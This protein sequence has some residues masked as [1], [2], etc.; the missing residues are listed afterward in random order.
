MQK[1]LFL[2]M[3][4]LSTMG[5]VAIHP[6]PAMA[7]EAPA[8]NIT[9]KGQVVDDMGEPLTGATIKVKGTATG[10]ITD[11]DGNFELSVDPNATLEVSY[12]GFQNQDVQVNGRTSLPTIKMASDSEIL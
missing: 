8:P 2:L 1:Q 10:T 12:V 11:L 6:T 3:L 4:G 9:V 5:G 7:L